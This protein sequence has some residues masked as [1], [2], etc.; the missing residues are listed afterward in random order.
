MYMR[1][2]KRGYVHG[3]MCICTYLYIIKVYI[4]VRICTIVPMYAYVYTEIILRYAHEYA[5]I[6]MRIF[7]NMHAYRNTFLLKKMLLT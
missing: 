5:Y 6:H 4:N 7:W 2:G 3:K 1:I